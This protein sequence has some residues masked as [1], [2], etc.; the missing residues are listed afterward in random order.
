[1]SNEKTYKN[2]VKNKPLD[3]V[4]QIWILRPSKMLPANWFFN[5]TYGKAT[6][7]LWEKSVK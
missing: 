2:M 3:D 4:L 7:W 6:N 5:S 1:M